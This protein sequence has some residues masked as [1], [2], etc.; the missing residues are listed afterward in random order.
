MPEHILDLFKLGLSKK[1]KEKKK[2][3]KINC[4]NSILKRKRKVTVVCVFLIKIMYP[5]SMPELF[6]WQHHTIVTPPDTLWSLCAT[7]F[8]AL[9]P[10][11]IA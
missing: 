10:G 8:S 6:Q 7:P 9:C 1:K 11:L 2:S 4:P 3:V 5:N